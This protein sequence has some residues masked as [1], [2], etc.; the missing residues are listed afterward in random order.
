MVLVYSFWVFVVFVY[1]CLRVA[2]ICSNGGVC[3][4]FGYDGGYEML[5]EQFLQQVV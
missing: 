1:V 3:C 2:N 5:C 4:L